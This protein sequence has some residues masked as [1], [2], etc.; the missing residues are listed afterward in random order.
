MVMTNIFADQYSSI[1]KQNISLHVDEKYLRKR[2]ERCE[3]LPWF[4]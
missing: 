1:N 2:Q 4:N 3:I